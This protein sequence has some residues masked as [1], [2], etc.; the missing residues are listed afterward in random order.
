MKIITNK[1][2]YSNM[3]EFLD[4]FLDNQNSLDGISLE[5]VLARDGVPMSIT[6]TAY[7]SVDNELIKQ[8]QNTKSDNIKNDNI[9]PLE[10]V[11]NKLRNIK[12]KIVINFIPIPTIAFAQDTEAINKI[13]E[14]QVS[15]LFSITN[16][17]PA[18]NF[19]ISSLS[20]NIIFHLKNRE[21]KNKIG[22]ILSPYDDSYVDV[23]FYVF[24]PEMLNLS[25][26]AEQLSINKELMISCAVC[27]NIK[28]VYEFLHNP[29]AKNL[30]EIINKVSFISNYPIIAYKV[31]NI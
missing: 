17:Y 19:Y 24:P 31:L 14:D 18:L 6:T 12:N 10:R 23:D 20:R 22:V 4:E 29:K 26:M 16:K 25:I 30:N 8:I 5:V 7:E 13:N 9:W 15:S 28:T 1:N 27:Q 3:G 21:T 11:L 2:F